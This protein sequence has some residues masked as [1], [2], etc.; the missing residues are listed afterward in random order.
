MS[1]V[2]VL[3][4]TK[5]ASTVNAH[6]GSRMTADKQMAI[7]FREWRHFGFGRRQGH[8]VPGSIF[9]APANVSA[10]LPPGRSEREGHDN[11]KRN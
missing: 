2:S 4:E 11:E 8:A 1:S 5:Y 6:A 9:F 7:L 10:F 3:G